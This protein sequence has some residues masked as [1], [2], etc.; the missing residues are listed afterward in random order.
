MGAQ[1]IVRVILFAGVY[2]ALFR[3]FLTSIRRL[4]KLSPNPNKDIVGYRYWM[5]PHSQGWP[6]RRHTMPAR[7][8]LQNHWHVSEGR[9][10]IACRLSTAPAETLARV[11]TT[12]NTINTLVIMAHDACHERLS[13][14]SLCPVTVVVC[15]Y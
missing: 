6:S 10:L 11:M 15:T 3:L 5:L 8:R 7:C 12:G 9:V 14:Y 2:E 1:S 13:Q 4:F